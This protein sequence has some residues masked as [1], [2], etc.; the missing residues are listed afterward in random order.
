MHFPLPLDLA[1]F[2]GVGEL[3]RGVI[4]GK[5]PQADEHETEPNGQNAESLE[6][7]RVQGMGYITEEFLKF[8]DTSQLLECFGMRWHPRCYGTNVM[9]AALQARVLRRVA[10]ELLRRGLLTWE[11][12]LVLRRLLSE[13]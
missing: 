9:N 5:A 2:R 6:S 3:L 11:M 1:Q 12:K 7:L 8:Q 10:R 4:G 13:R